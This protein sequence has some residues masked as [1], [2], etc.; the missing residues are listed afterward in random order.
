[1][2]KTALMSLVVLLVATTAFCAFRPKVR[3]PSGGGR[4]V[5][6]TNVV[7]QVVTFDDCNVLDTGTNYEAYVVEASVYNNTGATIWLSL[8]STTGTL[9][10]AISAGVAI[11][12]PNAATI[13]FSR[14]SQDPIYTIALR[15]ASSGTTGVVWVAGN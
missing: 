9:A 1:M 2:K 3:L 12:L 4:M 5:T 14:T 8:N 6:L 7:A 11:P 13:D 15:L 10:T